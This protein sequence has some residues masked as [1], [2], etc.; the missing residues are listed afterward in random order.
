MRATHDQATFLDHTAARM[1]DPA[2]ATG[3]ELRPRGAG[4]DTFIIDSAGEIGT[5][6]IAD[7][8]AS[9]GAGDTLRLD[10]SDAY[11]SFAEV[12]IAASQSGGNTVLDFGSLGTVTLTGVALAKLVADDFVFG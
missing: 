4:D 8:R 3:E 10:L 9:H 7:F 12:I 2:G 5:N 6:M 1:K 11:D